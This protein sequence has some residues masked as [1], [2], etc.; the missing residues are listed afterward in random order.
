MH[1]GNHL[2]VSAGT[3][4]SKWGA[5]SAQHRLIDENETRLFGLS[6]LDQSFPKGGPA[7]VARVEVGPAEVGPG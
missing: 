1:S 4:A 3:A 2:D 6:R 7:E 5:N